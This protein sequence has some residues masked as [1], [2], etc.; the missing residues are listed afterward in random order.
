M[1]ENPNQ[2]DLQLWL[3]RDLIPRQNR[4][5]EIFWNILGEVGNSIDPEDL[6][7]I[8]LG[9]RGIK[10]SK[11]NELLG[12]PYQVMDLIRDFDLDEGLNIRLLNWFGHGL[13]L[14][15]LLGKNH[16]KAPLQPLSENNWAFDQSPT[17]WEYPATLLSGAATVTPSAEL[18]E[19]STF[20]QWHKPL[21]IS[22]E[23]EYIKTR[24]L[25]ELKKLIF[26][27]S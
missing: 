1:K 17:P 8:H 14:F 13:F 15:V 27:L 26:L 20:Y 9:S 16:P 10:L 11:G 21:E 25:D 23:I 12:Y 6:Q 2:L 24:I 3:D 22:G 4:L 18:L 5:K 7:Q 19:K